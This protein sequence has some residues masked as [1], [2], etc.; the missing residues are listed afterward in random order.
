MEW[1]MFKMTEWSKNTIASLQKYTDIFLSD[2][3]VI[4]GGMLFV[5]LALAGE[6]PLKEISSVS[7]DPVKCSAFNEG[8]SEPGYI[9]LQVACDEG[10]CGGFVDFIRDK[11]KGKTLLQNYCDRS[12]EEFYSTRSIE[13]EKNCEYKKGYGYCIS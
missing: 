12:A 11:C 2:R 8:I 10:L 13:C 1:E 5:S 3:A 7:E 6:Q 4:I 9:V